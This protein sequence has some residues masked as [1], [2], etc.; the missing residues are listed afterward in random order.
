MP[1][2]LYGTRLQGIMVVV[3][4]TPCARLSN[5]EYNYRDTLQAHALDGIR[6]W[7]YRG[8]E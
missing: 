4:I 8:G 1:D 3:F 5:V 2:S 6:H 7:S